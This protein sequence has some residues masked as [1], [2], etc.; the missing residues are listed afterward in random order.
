MK[1]LPI[2]TSKR[3]AE[4]MLEKGRVTNRQGI[5]LL[6]FTV[7]VS[8]AVLFVPAITATTAGRDG[9][10]SVLT[11]AT[12]YGLLVALVIIKLGMK[13]L[14]KTL[15][16]YAPII[17]GSFLGKIIG[18]AYVLW[19]IHINSVIVRE[20]GDF[21]LASF[22]PETPLIAFVIMLLILGAWAAKSGLEVIC[23]ANEFIFPLFILSVTAIFVL[24]VW[25]ADFSQL[26][27]VMENGVKPVFRGALDPMAWRGEIIIVAMILPY[28]SDL[29]KTG[30]YLVF[31]VILIGLVL[32][33]ATVFTVAVVGELTKYLSFP[34]FELA[35][36]ISIGRFIERMEALVLVMWVAGVTIK[37]AVFYYVAVLGAAQLFELSDYRPI[38]L[39]VGLI[40]GIWSLELFQN[41]GQL[42]EWLTKT[43][44]LYAYIFE[45]GI[46]LLLLT[47]AVLRKKGGDRNYG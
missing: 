33:L 38:V 18:G 21:L 43:L 44:P 4:A 39:P 27:P 8:T 23:R 10:I 19:F 28:I 25:E 9:W 40:L 46:P 30:K 31:S 32:T 41:S 45:I 26:L 42:I 6:A 13:F 14:D 34:F 5:L 29:E 16:Q 12:I 17:L 47:V 11:V 15:V 20:F 35:R 2:T 37:V 36:C 1:K 24:A 22:M 7:V 3:G